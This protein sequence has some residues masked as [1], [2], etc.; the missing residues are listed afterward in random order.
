MKATLH[1][2]GG[3]RGNPGPAAIGVVL[4]DAAGVVVAELARPIG[5]ATNNIA[6]YT[7]LIEGLKLAAQRGV[8][9]IEVLCDSQL[10][11]SQIEGRWKIKSDAIRQLA[12]EAKRLLNDF[13]TASVE[14]VSRADNAD[15]DKLVNQALDA[16]PEVTALGP[17]FSFEVEE[18]GPPRPG[19]GQGSLL[20]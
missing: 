17:A 14:Q 15:A 4:R 3:A 13:T 9:D 18:E 16:D 12:V 1:T 8:T 10:V 2:D 20:D 7:A 5:K 19:P 6:E 11:V